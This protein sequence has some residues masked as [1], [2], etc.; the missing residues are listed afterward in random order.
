MVALSMTNPI[1]PQ[2]QRCKCGYPGEHHVGKK[3]Y[4]D[5]CYTN[6]DDE[7]QEKAYDSI[8]AVNSICNDFCTYLCNLVLLAQRWLGVTR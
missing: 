4:C 8:R 3:W 5:E 2:K 7:D 6:G 1:T